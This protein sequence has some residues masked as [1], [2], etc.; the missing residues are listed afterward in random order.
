MLDAD[1]LLHEGDRDGRE[2]AAEA[3]LLSKASGG[4]LDRDAPPLRGAFPGGGAL[5][6]VTPALPRSTA[7]SKVLESL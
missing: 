6:G 1:A 5:V 2:A 4:C 3:G 7:Q